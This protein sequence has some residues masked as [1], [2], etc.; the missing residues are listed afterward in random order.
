MKILIDTVGPHGSETGTPY[1]ALSD[2]VPPR[3]GEVVA[4]ARRLRAA[5]GTP[6]G[7][8]R[9]AS[10]LG[11]AC[12]EIRPRS[13]PFGSGLIHRLADRWGYSEKLLDAS[14]AALLKPFTAGT[15]GGFARKVPTRRN[16]IGFVMPGNVPGA[17]L[18]EV[19]AALLSGSAVLIKTASGE[20]LFFPEFARLVATID[21][22]ISARIAV[23][24]WGRGDSDLTAALRQ[25]CDRLV[26][27]G[28]DD[29]V[30]NL[31]DSAGSRGSGGSGLSQ[32]FTGFGSRVSGAI[33]T[34]E[35]VAKDS[36]QRAIA[37]L[38]AR[39]VTLFEQRGCLSPHH[40]FVEDNDGGQACGFAACLA[41]EMAALARELPP[42]RS[43][44]LEP[45]SAVRRA[46][47]SA[48]WRGLGG[49]QVRLWEGG[50]LGW[51]VIYDRDSPFRVSPG[52]RTVC[53]SPFNGAA[54]LESRLQPVKG[55]I[56][57]FA[58][59]G[60]DS[61][62]APIHAMLEKF[63]ATYVC[64]PGAMQSPPLDW[65]HGGGAFLRLLLER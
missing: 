18:H 20:P 4:T 5:L 42:P 31:Q 12:L 27:F 15:I 59:A 13:R 22:R 51:T 16:L 19:V 56:E 62:T 30:A 37:K 10:V 8:D 61:G 45:A 11:A 55:Q 38:V 9:V 25:S 54:S 48:R 50:A 46:R 28:G 44:G 43:L 63:G 53:V 29:T 1:D 21:G 36:T 41:Q 65:P 23:F 32:A 3:P 34:H 33:V 2:R 6:L 39:D 24:N 52:F 40:V 7:S 64:R 58:L 49:Q 47:E 26:V 17:G 35:A 60:A 14:L 57:A